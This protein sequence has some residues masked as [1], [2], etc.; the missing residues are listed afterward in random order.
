MMTSSA[1]QRY[2][3]AQRALARAEEVLRQAE[4]DVDACA[5]QCEAA[6]QAYLDDLRAPAL[7]TRL[8]HDARRVLEVTHRELIHSSKKA[9]TPTWSVS[10]P[11][12]EL[13]A[14]RWVKVRNL[15]RMT[16]QQ[17]QAMTAEEHAQAVAA[18]QAASRQR[19]HRQAQSPLRLGSIELEFL[20]HLGFLRTP[21]GPFHAPTG[22]LF[23][24]AASMR[25]NVQIAERLHEKGVLAI[26][27]YT[28]NAYAGGVVPDWYRA[29]MTDGPRADEAR[30]LL[31]RP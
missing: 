15:A 12:H 2:E 21:S 17:V 1:H 31:R 22:F 26:P 9:G 27:G 8:V 5:S 23:G 25:G 7:K 19:Q 3:A 20:D 30:A 24:S 28:P 10:G 16:A 18:H 6:E 11:L 4:R 14:G 13:R 29:P